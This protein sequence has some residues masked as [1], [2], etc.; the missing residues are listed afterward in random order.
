MQF[1][2]G[3]TKDIRAVAY[4]PDGRLIS[5]GSDRTVRVWAPLAGTCLQTLK[6]RTV[7]YAVAVSPDGKLLAF[8]G[9]QPASGPGPNTIKFWDLEHG[10]SEDEIVWDV[11]DNFPRYYTSRS[12]WYLTFSS[13]GQYLAAACRSPGSAN[14]LYGAGGH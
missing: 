7:V 1:L 14:I 12:I 3:H 4:T 9:R 2:Q 10:Q 5:G 11:P 13:D 6:A 8:A